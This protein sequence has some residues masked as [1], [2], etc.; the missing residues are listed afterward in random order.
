MIPTDNDL[1]I[2]KKELIN[3]F[4]SLRAAKLLAKDKYQKVEN[5]FKNWQNLG[6][7]KQLYTLPP[8]FLDTFIKINQL[9]YFY[10]SKNKGVLSAPH[11]EGFYVRIKTRCGSID[12]KI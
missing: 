1:K 4:S 11:G 9:D 2:I 3:K 5:D 10:Y 7:R 8:C 6:K 12:Y